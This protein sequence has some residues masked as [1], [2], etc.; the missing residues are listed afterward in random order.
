[1]AINKYMLINNGK[2]DKVRF[3]SEQQIFS[4]SFGLVGKLNWTQIETENENSLERI[5]IVYLE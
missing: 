3:L 2:S 4:F 5:T 1:M